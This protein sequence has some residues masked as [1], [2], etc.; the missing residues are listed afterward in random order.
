MSLTNIHIRHNNDYETLSLPLNVSCENFNEHLRTNPLLRNK[1]K[2]ALQNRTVTFRN[3]I[4]KEG[5]PIIHIQQ[6][7]MAH[8]SSKQYGGKGA[9]LV[10]DAATTCH[11]MAIRSCYKRSNIVSSLSS[12]NAIVLGSLTHIDSDNYDECIKL[13]FQEHVKYH[14]SIS[15]DLQELD[16]PLN[17]DIHLVGGYCDKDNTSVKLTKYLLQMIANISSHYSKTNI[18]M[19]LE[20][21]VVSSLNDASILLNDGTTTTTSNTANV[22]PR[23]IARGMALHVT[24]GVVQLLETMDPSH[25][26][27]GHILR[28]VRLFSSQSNSLLLVHNPIQEEIRISPFGWRHDVRQTNILLELP[29]YLLLKYT[30]TSPECEDEDFCDT[31]RKSLIFMRDVSVE[32]VFGKEGQRKSIVFQFHSDWNRHVV[33]ESIEW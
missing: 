25:I 12:K 2:T 21:C 14:R 3:P 9:I 24:S 19:N 27:P 30:S 18:S 7:E 22:S 8:V 26:G 13:M 20:T 28:N 5:I 17:M 16:E 31:M 33:S 32:S 29:D 6:R 11:V 15:S 4:A 1:A 23:P 10:S